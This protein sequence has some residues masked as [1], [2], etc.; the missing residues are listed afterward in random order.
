MTG[1]DYKP[2][3]DRMIPRYEGGYGWDRGD[4]GGPTNFGIT[5]WDLADHRGVKMDSM[6]RWAPLVKAMTLAEAED[7]YRGKYAVACHFSDLP[8]GVDCCW[9]DYGVNSGIGRPIRVAQSFLGVAVDGVFGPQTLAAVQTYGASKFISRMCAE[10]MQFLHGLRIW[11]TFG[12][13]WTSRVNDL[14]IYCN[15][16]AGQGLPTT[17]ADFAIEDPTQMAKS[18]VSTLWSKMDHYLG[19]T[20]TP[21]IN[22]PV[23]GSIG[24]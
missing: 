6:S 21:F 17:V 24:V 19:N 8:A 12:R 7:I 9:F 5:C 10:R 23:A 14:Q 3:V 22:A 18:Y 16:L 15:R 20:E 2:F 4:P 13:G 1:L 11:S